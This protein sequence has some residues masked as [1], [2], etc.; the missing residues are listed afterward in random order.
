MIQKNYGK[1]CLKMYE[2]REE[3]GIEAAKDA[4]GCIRGLLKEKDEIN[5]IFAAAPS[6]SDFLKA[7]CEEPGIEWNRI[8]AYHMDEYIGLPLGHEKSFN[9]FLSENIFDI[10]PFKSVHLIDGSAPIDRELEEYTKLLNDAHTDITFMGIGENGHI[11][12]NDPAVADFHDKAVIK[13]VKLDN[14]CREQQ[15]HD[16]CFACIEDV[17]KYAITVTVPRLVASDHIFCIVPTE[18]KHNALVAALTGPIS[19]KCP[20]SILRTIDNVKM[21]VDK[22]CAGNLYTE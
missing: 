20:A 9:H 2:T 4:A 11:A 5:C 19:E 6:Q 16:K 22:A 18:K 10:K 14:V 7:L 13:K 1:V 17:P 21:Y 12:F 8:N 3:M 15:V